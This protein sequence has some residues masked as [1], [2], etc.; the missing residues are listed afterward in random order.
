MDH[1]SKIRTTLEKIR[2]S[3]DVDPAK[4]TEMIGVRDSAYQ[5]FIKGANDLPVT[6]LIHLA[7]SLD[8]NVEQLISGEFDVCTLS[9]RYGGERSYIPDRFNEFAES[10]KML[11][12]SYLDSAELMYGYSHRKRI[13]NKLQVT[14][15]VFAD[16][17][18]KVNMVFTTEAIDICFSYYGEYIADQAAKKIVSEFKSGIKL[19]KNISPLN[20]AVFFEYITQSNC[21]TLLDRNV[22]WR[23]SAKGDDF[24][25][26]AGLPNKDLHPHFG[27]RIKSKATETHRMFLIKHLLS[28]YSIQYDS[29]VQ[30]ES[31]FHGSNELK[32]RIHF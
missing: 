18:S 4:W 8:L 6:S 28:A 11:A 26:I 27:T 7:N 14:D 30:T 17:K 16:M 1:A 20:P 31:M 22:F 3:I 32:Y 10:N 9:K 25:E 2:T 19:P 5:N 21:S 13:L 23:V 29:V 15:A 12:K 24:V